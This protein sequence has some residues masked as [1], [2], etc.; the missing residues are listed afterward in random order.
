MA[1]VKG[2]GDPAKRP[3]TPPGAMSRQDLFNKSDE[4]AEANPDLVDVQDE[5]HDKLTEVTEDVAET[6]DKVVPQEKKYKIK[7]NGQDRE[8]TEAELIERAQK[9]ES[10][11]QRFQEAAQLKREAEE[12][13]QAPPKDPVKPEVEENYLAEARRL[14]MGSEEEAAEVIKRLTQR[15]S[16]NEADVNR[17]I[18]ER[19]TFTTSVERFKT[20]YPELF[21]DT[22]LSRLVASRDDELVKAGDK[23]S[24]Y[25]RYKA[26]G[27]E[28]REWAGKVKPVNTKQERKASITTLPTANVRQ[29][30]GQEEDKEESTSDVIAGMAKT[31]G[32]GYAK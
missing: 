24:Y 16:L 29:S 1:D 11:D 17:K 15:P 25:D 21:S 22:Y 10:A 27:D 6:E 18:D 2:E 19:L 3:N 23:R 5:D 9:A 26:I 13:R 8:Y 14:Q 31:R 12:L 32:Q 30:G 7:V 4:D 28:I 20:E